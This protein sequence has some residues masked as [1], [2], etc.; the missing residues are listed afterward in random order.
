MKWVLSLTGGRIS[1]WG[2]NRKDPSCAL[3]SVHHAVF[4]VA[5]FALLPSIRGDLREI[6]GLLIGLVN[7]R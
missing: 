2:D 5:V 6:V 1:L 4:A 7:K 3:P